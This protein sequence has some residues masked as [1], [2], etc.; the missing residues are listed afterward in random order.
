MRHD[1]NDFLSK[2]GIHN[3]GKRRKRAPDLKCVVQV[4]E[5]VLKNTLNGPLADLGQQVALLP[6]PGGPAAVAILP[7]LVQFVASSRDA[8]YNT[9]GYFDLHLRRMTQLELM[10]FWV[11]LFVAEVG[12]LLLENTIFLEDTNKA[13]DLLL[14]DECYDKLCQGK[15]GL[16]TV[17]WHVGCLCYVEECPPN[18]YVPSCVNCGGNDGSK[19][20]L[21]VGIQNKC[22]S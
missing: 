9:M 13:C 11:V 14:M 5:E 20:C 18:D 17:G 4:A 8:C 10:V 2:I 6:Q 3:C 19:H 16:C 15:N 7:A 1:I 22:F 12:E 21:G